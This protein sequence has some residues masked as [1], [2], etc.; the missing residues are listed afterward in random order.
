[1]TTTHNPM[2]KRNSNVQ[3]HVLGNETIVH[4]EHN[5][6]VHVLNETAR[7]IWDHCDGLT[8]RQQVLKELQQMYPDTDPD[9]VA[10]DFCRTLDTLAS[11]GIV[12]CGD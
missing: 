5:H 8:A 4:D 3:I 10:E 9:A 6:R 12:A 2:P 11:A 7:H 1:M